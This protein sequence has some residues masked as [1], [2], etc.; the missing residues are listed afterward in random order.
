LGGWAVAW[1]WAGGCSL[2]SLAAACARC[3]GDACSLRVGDISRR[4]ERLKAAGVPR[5]VALGPAVLAGT[6][7]CV[8]ARSAS[9]NAACRIVGLI[10]L[11]W[12]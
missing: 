2:G 8:A 4:D 10:N 1:A 6:S 12:G 5:C 3:S 7:R 11:I 9:R